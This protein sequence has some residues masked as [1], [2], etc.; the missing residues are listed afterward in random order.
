MKKINKKLICIL[1]GVLL[2]VLIGV[3]LVLILNWNN[4]FH[5][6]KDKEN[7]KKPPVTD[8]VV[9]DNVD[10]GSFDADFIS[11]VWLGGESD[12]KKPSGG[13]TSSN[14]EFDYD[15]IPETE[16]IYE[17]KYGKLSATEII[18]TLDSKYLKIIG[19]SA[20]LSEGVALDYSAATISFYA[21]CN[22]RVRVTAE[23]ESSVYFS[24][25]IDG[26][27]QSERICFTKQSPTQTIAVI[28]EK[29]S[30]EF[31]L[32]RESEMSYGP[33]TV[34]K[35]KLT[36]G[37]FEEKPEDKQY[38]IEFVGDGL[39]SGYGALCGFLS[40]GNSSG[41][42]SENGITCG[43]ADNLCTGAT[44][45][46]AY[47]T[48][49]KIGADCSII[50]HNGIGFTKCDGMSF[51]IKDLYD[52]ESKYRSDSVFSFVD[53]RKPDVVVVNLGTNDA[54]S[55]RND[56]S[57]KSQF[58]N[59]VKR[60][61]NGYDDQNLKIVFVTG[62]MGDSKTN[63]IKKL[64]EDKNDDNMYH[65]DISAGTSGHGGRPSYLEHN[66]AA[67]VLSE[68]IKSILT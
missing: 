16:I 38:Y 4:I 26:V 23:V 59:L 41:V 46:Y 9:E 29:G 64:V 67:E 3:A 62:L 19:R 44:Y 42:V 40:N 20:S 45:S 60:I 55:G 61:R 31:E 27:R 43:G 30:H 53:A 33:C 63:A 66:N 48:A 12:T 2:L 18:P 14:I 36:R 17:D 22:E 6:K 34:T 51:Q 57:I 50:A 8:V 1:T 52:L 10:E 35:I 47:S 24:L 54:L 37:Y 13:G 25:Y 56:N 68:F 39:T 15:P 7:D 49:Q 11:R 5:S 32:V 28:K 58:N 65:I 21:V